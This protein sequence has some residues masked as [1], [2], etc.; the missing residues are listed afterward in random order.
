MFSFLLL[1]AS[2]SPVLR[3]DEV[4]HP[5]TERAQIVIRFLEN[6]PVPSIPNLPQNGNKISHLLLIHM[7]CHLFNTVTHRMDRN[8]LGAS[9]YMT[10]LPHLYGKWALKQR[11]HI[12]F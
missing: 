3:Y 2:S 4:Q 8:I 6:K 9:S 5:T 1:G 10:P 7:P 11:M 12:C